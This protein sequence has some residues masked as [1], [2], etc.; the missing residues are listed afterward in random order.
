M[1]AATSNIVEI[2]AARCT[3]DG[4]R[5]QLERHDQAQRAELDDQTV[6]LAE[7]ALPQET[8]LEQ[9]SFWRCPRKR[10]YRIG[11]ALVLAREAP[12]STENSLAKWLP[13]SQLP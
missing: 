4:G 13:K 11:D 1:A 10:G 8:A 3:S 9:L 5:A 6:R 12:R 2:S 7:S